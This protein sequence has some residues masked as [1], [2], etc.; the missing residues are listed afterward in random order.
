MK[1]VLGQMLLQVVKIMNKLLVVEDKKLNSG[2]FNLKFF[3]D[4]SLNIQGEVI[5]HDI[6]SKNKDLALEVSDNSS[7]ALYQVKKI[8]ADYSIHIKLLENAKFT[9]NM[10]I[11]NDGK[12]KVIIDIEMPENG[13]C[14]SVNVR[15][16]NTKDDDNLDIVCNGY[17]NK[18][19]KDNELLENLKGLIVNDG[20]SIKISP[21]MVVD[22]NEVIANHL[23]TIGSFNEEELFYLEAL[24]LSEDMAKK[25]L[26]QSFLKN[27]MSP[28]ELEFLELGGEIHE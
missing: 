19:T 23:V 9:L 6:N 24:G 7:L 18:D 27:N 12:N 25:I 16:I 2:E 8:N 3:K 4:V 15:A 28:I 20:D 17:I 13:A 1:L 11:I 10:L 21:I 26:T 22:T 5:I 14:S